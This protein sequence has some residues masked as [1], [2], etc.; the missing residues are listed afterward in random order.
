MIPEILSHACDLEKAPALSPFK[1]CFCI[2]I[3]PLEIARDKLEELV[4]REGSVE[5]EKLA[6]Q[7]LSNGLG[8][9][10]ICWRKQ[11]DEFE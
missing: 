9:L 3:E 5:S 2:D 4:L 7:I 6:S 8:V 11:E 10:R 1:P